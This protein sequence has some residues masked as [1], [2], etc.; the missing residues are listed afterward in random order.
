MASLLLEL[1]RQSDRAKTVLFEFRYEFGIIL[2]LILCLLKSNKAQSILRLLDGKC[3]T[4]NKKF[5]H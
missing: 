5:T 4:N 3:A 2:K 1:R